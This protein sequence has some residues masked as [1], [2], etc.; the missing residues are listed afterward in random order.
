MKKRNNYLFASDWFDEQF[1]GNF[2]YAKHP[3]IDILNEKKHTIKDEKISSRVLNH[4]YQAGIIVDDRPNGK[5]WKKFSLSEIVWITIVNK[6]R[7]F[8]LDLNKI[9]KVKDD[10]S[11][12]SR[13]NK[14]NEC[15]LLD[16]YILLAT[17]SKEPVKLLVF[18]SGEAVIETQS[19][20]DVSLQLGAFT[21]DYISIDMNN[22]IYMLL[23]KK[24]Q[25]TDYLSYQLD[26]VQKEIQKKIH[27]QEIDSITVK[28]KDDHFLISSDYLADNLELAVN[29]RRHIS[30]G[31]IIE[32]IH[33]GHSKWKVVKR[34]KIS[35][36][37]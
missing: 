19:R 14:P 36:K 17:N 30:H 23:K 37:G 34:E 5:G 8:G 13:K 31:R 28:I 25:E 4:W 9:S 21:E 12:Y 11:M 15:P 33:E 16:F 35:I 18:E 27:N 7:R 1:L 6:L 2:L 32:D 3:V 10:L 20:I 24:G 22:L 26:E 29:I